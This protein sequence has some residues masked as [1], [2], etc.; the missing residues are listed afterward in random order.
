MKVFAAL[1]LFAALSPVAWSESCDRE[2]TV[3][4]QKDYRPFTYIAET[5]EIIGSDIRYFTQLMTTLDCDFRFIPMS[6]EQTLQELDGGRVDITLYASKT[7]EREKR[8]YYSVPYRN[9]LAI[10][11]MRSKDP[12]SAEV[13]QLADIPRLKL[14]V[15]T[16]FAAWRSDELTA[17]VR[18]H[19]E[20]FVDV[21]EAQPA[22]RMLL[23]ERVDAVIDDASA[24]KLELA[25][26]G[27]G[28]AVKY[29][30]VGFDQDPNHIIFNKATVSEAM[31]KRFN[32]EINVMDYADFLVE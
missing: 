26:L 21:E 12:R 14:N 17:M 9:Q 24:V 30:R 13:K 31:V 1:L 20:H 15:A 5:G 11:A 10:L 25:L 4:I 19:R 22:V 7:A 16:D 2:Y 27:Y 8:Y 29:L 6:W 23:S 32:R 28:D 18:Q 3:S